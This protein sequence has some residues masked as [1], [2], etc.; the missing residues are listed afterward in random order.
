MKEKGYFTRSDGTKSNDGEDSVPKKRRAKDL[1]SSKQK[2]QKGTKRTS[3][4]ALDMSKAKGAG[5]KKSVGKGNKK[6]KEAD[7]SDE[8]S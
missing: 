7:A 3:Q 2:K 5:R 8:S 4:E 1:S 6:A